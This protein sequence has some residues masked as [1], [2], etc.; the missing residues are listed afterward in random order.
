MKRETEKKYYTVKRVDIAAFHQLDELALACGSLYSETV[1]RYWR[2]VRKQDVWL[3]S[4]SM[5]RWLTS[6][7]MHAHTADATV[8]AFFASLDSWRE[9]RKT[10]P[11]AK[12]PHK[13]R[14]FFRIEYKQTAMRLR[15]GRLILSNGRGNQ[16][17]ILD[18]PWAL[19]ATLVIHWKET[20]GYEAIATYRREK[21]VPITTGKVAAIDLG[22]VHIAALHDGETSTIFNGG[23]LRSK[24]RYQ[25]KLKAKLFSKIDKQK[26]GSKRRKKTIRSK[27]KQLTKLRNQIRDIEHKTSRAIVSTLQSTGVQTVVIGDVRNIRQDNDKGTDANQKIHQWSHGKIRFYTT[28][29]SE[30]VGMEVKLQEESYTSQECPVCAARRKMKGRVFECLSCGFIGHRDAVGSWNI[31]KKYLK[32]TAQTD[33]SVVGF[34]AQPSGIRFHPHLSVA[35]E[36]RNAF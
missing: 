29:K 10:D 13:P 31:R 7:K 28:Y 19:P 32:K 5:M 9:R 24:R 35:Q 21:P 25:N 16:P 11:K 34:M 12:P 15:D 27:K 22:E 36:R 33:S 1:K 3:K 17:V 18:W 23:E 4:S 2:T 14:K 30:A 8:Q 20:G 6:D 26:K